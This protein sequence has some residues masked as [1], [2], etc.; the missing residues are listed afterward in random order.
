[1]HLFSKALC[2]FSL[3]IHHIFF[4]IASVHT[5]GG[6]MKISAAQKIMLEVFVYL[7]VS[8]LFQQEIDIGSFTFQNIQL[9]LVLGEKWGFF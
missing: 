8:V 2:S 1:M 9:T 5:M 4:K 3:V 7:F 6:S